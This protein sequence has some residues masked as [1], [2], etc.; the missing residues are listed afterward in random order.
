M[1]GG[2]LSIAL[3]GLNSAQTGLDTVSENISNAN[4][5][6]YIKE[7]T[8]FSN[9]Q[10][11]NS[12][13][14]DG[15]TSA[16]VQSTNNFS[17]Q[18]TLSASASKS[19]A[20]QLQSLLTSAQASF[21][22][23]S[24]SGISEQLNTMYNDFSALS[25]TPTQSASYDQVVA[26]AKNVATTI[27][28]AAQNL[29]SVY[30]QASSNAATLTQTINS[31]LQQVAALNTQLAST[32]ETPGASNTL[33]DQQ[34]QIVDQLASELGVTPISGNSGQT[35]LLVGGVALVQGGH[36][37]QIAFTPSNNP[38][39]SSTPTQASVT[40]TASGTHVPVTGGELGATLTMMNSK[41]PTFGGY[42]NS[43]STTLANQVNTQLANGASATTTSGD[44]LFLPSSGGTINAATISVNPAISSN[45]QLIAASSKPYSPG[46]GS[47]AQTIASQ[48]TATNGAIAGWASSVSSVGLAVQSASSLTTSAT[49]IY[50]QAYS[51]SQAV[52]GV[53]INT[54]MVNL[55]NYQQMYQA[56]AK[57]IS[58]VAATLQS[59]IQNV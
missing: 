52:S 32:S 22:E 15:V 57:V 13:I 21:N 34:N 50:N 7:T 51:A 36:V 11:P 56:S 30:N 25:S 37:S 54:Q 4:T 20:N 10:T 47:N 49:N 40:L 42:L 17:R 29:T 23:P 2:S 59:L 24:S 43:L 5:A 9:Q 1:S 19:Y 46:N 41:L 16:V 14:G 26:A 38:I 31:Q 3:S 28:Q 6:G 55:V 53:S 35:T 39:S 48:Q 33:I 44:P 27:N 45:P 18:L 12:P 8:I 58:T